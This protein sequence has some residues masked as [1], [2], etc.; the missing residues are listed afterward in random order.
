MSVRKQHKFWTKFADETG[1][2]Q[3]GECKAV[4][5]AGCVCVYVG[6]FD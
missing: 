2:N 3:G 4:D 1:R 5:D 6:S